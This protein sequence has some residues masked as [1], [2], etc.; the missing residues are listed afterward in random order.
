MISVQLGI[1]LTDALVTLRAHSYA[2]AQPISQVSA[3]VV[4][5]RLSFAGQLATFPQ[6]AARGQT[7]AET[8]GNGSVSPPRGPAPPRQ[9]DQGQDP[10][11]KDEDEEMEGE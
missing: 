8:N 6:A 3:D 9:Q 7:G 2:Q 5:R 10:E 11:D 1:S 4:G